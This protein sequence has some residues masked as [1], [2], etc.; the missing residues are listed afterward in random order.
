MALIPGPGR[1][2]LHGVI[3]GRCSVRRCAR[4]SSSAVR[5]SS[6]LASSPRSR[7]AAHNV[8]IGAP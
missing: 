7:Q 2:A 5:W 1:W 8:A 4:R 6:S 3:T